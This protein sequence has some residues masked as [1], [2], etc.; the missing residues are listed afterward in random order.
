MVVRLRI[1]LQSSPW[2]ADQSPRQRRR[3]I[4]GAAICVGLVA[5]YVVW[6]IVGFAVHAVGALASVRL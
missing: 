3:Y 2:W 5:L 6:C 1:W 4:L